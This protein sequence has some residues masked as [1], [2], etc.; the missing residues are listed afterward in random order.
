MLKAY[1]VRAISIAV[2]TGATGAA[3]WMADDAK[4]RSGELAGL[5][6]A[7]VQLPTV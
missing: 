1:G 6:D 7:L 3:L 4:D 5:L 2:V